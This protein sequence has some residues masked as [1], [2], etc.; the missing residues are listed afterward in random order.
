MSA[1]EYHE[2]LGAWKFWVQ[3][4]LH[5]AKV[6]SAPRHRWLGREFCETMKFM[7]FEIWGLERPT[8]V[9]K[10]IPW[11]SSC[12]KVLSSE[13][14]SL[15]QVGRCIVALPYGLGGVLWKNEIRGF[16]DVRIEKAYK[17]PQMNTMKFL[18]HESFEFGGVCTWLGCRCTTNS[19]IA[20][21]GVLWKNE[22][23]GFWDVRVG[24]AYKCP[25]M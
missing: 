9:P 16:W 3:R 2:N 22:I 7:I 23:R 10:W 12:T 5:M 21:W 14:L 18:V 17:Y 6:G 11:N 25:Q 24:K 8:N 1:N 4:V 15:G 20:W 13:G 19:L